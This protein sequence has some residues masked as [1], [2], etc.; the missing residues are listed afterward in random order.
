MDQ[1]ACARCGVAQEEMA[2]GETV[3]E[4]HRS[5]VSMEL[6][7]FGSI[8]NFAIE[9]ESTG[10]AFYR[11]SA[12]NPA[13][14]AHSALFQEF[15]EDERKNEQTMLRT[16]RENVTEMILEPIYDFSRAS[17]LSSVDGVEGM[18]LKEF[19]ASALD[20]EEKAE[21]FYTQAAEKIRALPEV[22]RAL[23]RIGN[24][25]AAHRERLMVLAD[26]AG[27]QLGLPGAHLSGS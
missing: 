20:L 24:R 27:M 26:E 25:R 21:R 3:P 12:A 7:N 22:A 17:F 11:G 9:L 19:L 14:S 13:C 6:K 4:M 16:R 23:V 15:A 18:G 5:G 2:F 1:T 8:L 10:Q